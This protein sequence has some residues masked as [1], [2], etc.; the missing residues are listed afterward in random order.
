MRALSVEL[1]RSGKCQRFEDLVDAVVGHATGDAVGISG[2]HSNGNDSTG[3]NANGSGLNNHSNNHGNKNNT[4]KQLKR[5][6][7]ERNGDETTKNGDADGLVNGTRKKAKS[8]SESESGNCETEEV[9]E[10]DTSSNTAAEEENGSS[11]GEGGGNAVGND[12]AANVTEDANGISKG[13]SSSA[14]YAIPQTVVGDGVRFI[15]DALDGVFT[16]EEDNGDP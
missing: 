9:K 12:H 1:L 14:K 6:R 15:R 11:H 5:K 7:D 8:E 16:V 13:S 2:V 3:S 4:S 10:E